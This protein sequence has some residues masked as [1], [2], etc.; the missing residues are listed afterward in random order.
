M[1]CG[2]R[3]VEISVPFEFMA[4]SD[5]IVN[6]YSKVTFFRMGSTP[7]S[8]MIKQS[9]SR[10]GFIIEFFSVTGDI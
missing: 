6:K 1:S 9:Q 3:F 8:S 4:R 5:I 7:K 10:S 2:D